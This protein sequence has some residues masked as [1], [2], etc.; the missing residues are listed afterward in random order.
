MEKEA[1]ETVDLGCGWIASMHTDGSMT[2]VN[3]V[4]GW[5]NEL[6]AESV[7]LLRKII[8]ESEGE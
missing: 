6:P 7:A 3:K 8:K 4:D 2:F 1:R 5:R